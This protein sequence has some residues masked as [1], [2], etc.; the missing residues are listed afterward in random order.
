MVEKILADISLSHKMQRYNRLISVGKQYSILDMRQYFSSRSSFS[1]FHSL[2]RWA[3]GAMTLNI[4]L[5]QL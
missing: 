1:N 4:A 2:N 3:K 5:L